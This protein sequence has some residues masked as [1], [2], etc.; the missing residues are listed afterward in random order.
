MSLRLIALLLLIS[1]VMLG[2]ATP[3]ATDPLTLPDWQNQEFP[4]F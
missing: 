4:K 3:Q 2:C 1:V